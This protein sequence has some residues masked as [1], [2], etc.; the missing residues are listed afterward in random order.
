[1]CPGWVRTEFH[2]RAGINARSIPNFLWVDAASTVE[3]A[4]R[5]SERGRVVVVPSIRYSVIMWVIRHLPRAAVRWIS[6]AISSSRD[7]APVPAATH[8]AGTH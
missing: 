2:E 8:G 3:T 7:D 1:M 6:R 4:I 5:A